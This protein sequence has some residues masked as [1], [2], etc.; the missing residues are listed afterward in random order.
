MSTGPAKDDAA[1]FPPRVLTLEHDATASPMG[2]ALT[3]AGYSVDTVSRAADLAAALDR[4]AYDAVLLDLSPRGTAD[5]VLGAA[6]DLLAD[7]QSSPR[8]ARPAVIAVWPSRGRGDRGGHLQVDMTIATRSTGQ[9]LRE[10]EGAIAARRLAR[11]TEEIERLRR[12]VL[13]ARQTA[14]DLAQPLTTILAR[15]QL[16]KNSLKP[17]DPHMRAVSIICD[18]ADRLAQMME[19]FQKLKEMVKGPSLPRG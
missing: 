16:V 9:I 5:E 11:A 12:T 15:A 7:L 3:D 10:V 19:A 17:D 13:F 2:Q 1:V 8:D 18:E 4:G 14:H 6:G